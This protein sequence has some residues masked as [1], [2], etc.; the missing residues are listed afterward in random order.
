ML[1]ICGPD[2]AVRA[3]ARSGVGRDAAARQ[4]PRG[5]ARTAS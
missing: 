2:A 5:P 3:G 1:G 4:G